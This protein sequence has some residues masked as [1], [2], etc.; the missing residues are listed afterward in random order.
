MSWKYIFFFRNPAF[1]KACKLITSSIWKYSSISALRQVHCSLILFRLLQ[2]YSVYLSCFFLFVLISQ[3]L[4]YHSSLFPP[5][6]FYF[7]YFFIFIFIFLFLPSSCVNLHIGEA[8]FPWICKRKWRKNILEILLLNTYYLLQ[9]FFTAFYSLMYLQI[10]FF[11]YVSARNF[12]YFS[13]EW[14]SKKRTF[15]IASIDSLDSVIYLRSYL[16]YKQWFIEVHKTLSFLHSFYSSQ[17][18]GRIKRRKHSCHKHSIRILWRILRV[19]KFL[20]KQ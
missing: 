2:F 11:K 14:P 6:W 1:P 13:M 9:I 15:C 19:W 20:N 12:G 18:Y 4:V 5:Y 10:S 7:L 8:G 16:E 3:I 17:R